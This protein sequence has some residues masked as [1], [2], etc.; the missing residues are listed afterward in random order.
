MVSSPA[1]LTEATVSSAGAGETFSLDIFLDASVSDAG[2]DTIS[3]TLHY[4]NDL[5][6]LVNPPAPITVQNG[7]A[8][9]PITIIGTNLTLDSAT[10]ITTLHFQAMLTDTIH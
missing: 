3:F 5:L 8:S 4:W 7:E 10:P 2:L 6:N 1:S 9:V